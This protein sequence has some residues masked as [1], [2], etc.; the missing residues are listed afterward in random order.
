MDP[1]PVFPSTTLEKVD[2]SSRISHK[3]DTQ[4]LEEEDPYSLGSTSTTLIGLIIAIATIGIPLVAVITERP[5]E[6][7]SLVPTALE[8]DGS[9]STISVSM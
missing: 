9:K 3:D 2:S 6:R 1:E 4:V 7:E 5:L 8:R